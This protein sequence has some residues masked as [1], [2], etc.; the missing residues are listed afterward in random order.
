MIPRVSDT[1]WFSLQLNK[2]L[3]NLFHRGGPF[4]PQ[5]GEMLTNFLH[6]S[7]NIYPETPMFE[8]ILSCIKLWCSKG[9]WILTNH[10]KIS[11]AH[12]R[13]KTSKSKLQL[14][15]TF[16]KVD[17]GNKTL[18][19]S[20]VSRYWTYKHSEH[21]PLDQGIEPFNPSFLTKLKNQ[22]RTTGVPGLIFEAFRLTKKGDIDSGQ[23]I[24]KVSLQYWKIFK[25]L[26]PGTDTGL[27]K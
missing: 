5:T 8:R 9:K 21:I 6:T 12:F 25:T 2:H 14:C 13:S 4:Y 7:M 15:K 16:S 20:S 24:D 19:F 11:S 22:L 1:V 27:A 26:I 17:T 23:N 18:F 3:Y 10:S